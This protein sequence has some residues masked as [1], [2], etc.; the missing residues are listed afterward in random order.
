MPLPHG[1]RQLSK[2]AASESF[3]CF[4][5]AAEWAFG[6]IRNE[7]GFTPP[8]HTLEKRFFTIMFE[9]TDMETQKK[10][11][12]TERNRDFP[13]DPLFV[14]RKLAV[15]AEKTSQATLECVALRFNLGHSFLSLMEFQ[16]NGNL[17]KALKSQY[18]ADGTLLNAT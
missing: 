17:K 11:A 2:K 14:F 16:P 5:E 12:E 4:Q 7:G 13:Q 1:I 18:T 6:L 15:L 8:Q 9:T 10:I 3:H